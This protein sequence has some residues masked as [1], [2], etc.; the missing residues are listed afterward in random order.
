MK[1]KLY[2]SRTDKKLFGVCGGLAEY[3]G[4][5]ATVV[6]VILVLFCLAGGSGLI[7]YLVCA[8]VM[9]EEP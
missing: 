1:K 5:D 2:K 4:I 8:A 7:P 3:L 9:P 6:R